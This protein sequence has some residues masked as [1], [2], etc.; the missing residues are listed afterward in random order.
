M[1]TGMDQLILQLIEV[2]FKRLQLEVD[3]PNNY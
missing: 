2:I 3:R 1:A